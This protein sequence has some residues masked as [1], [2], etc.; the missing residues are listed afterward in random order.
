LQPQRQYL[1]PIREAH[2]VAR[3]MQ[4]GAAALNRPLADEL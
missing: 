3:E 1:L 4:P 2:R